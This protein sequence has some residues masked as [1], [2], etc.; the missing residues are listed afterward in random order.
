LFLTHS[1]GSCTLASYAPCSHCVCVTGNASCVSSPSLVHGSPRWLITSLK[2]MLRVVS[3]SSGDSATS[4]SGGDAGLVPSVPVP[5]VTSPA[6]EA[7]PVLIS[8]TVPFESAPILQSAAA[9]VV[10]LPVRQSSRSRRPDDC[11][12]GPPPCT[13]QPLL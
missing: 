5:T 7:V 4:R 13:F 3:V 9:P 10:H 11:H 6:A 1:F 12:A 8:P 2:L